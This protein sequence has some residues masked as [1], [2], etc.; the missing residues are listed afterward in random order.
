[1]S[2]NI[3]NRIFTNSIFLLT[4]TL[5]IISFYNLI[6]LSSLS[7]NYE[8]VKNSIESN[9][10]YYEDLLNSNYVLQKDEAKKILNCFIDLKINEIKSIIIRGIII[11]FLFYIFFSFSRWVTKILDLNNPPLD[12]PD[13]KFHAESILKCF[14]I[15][16]IIDIIFIFYEIIDLIYMINY[17]NK[18]LIPYMQTIFDNDNEYLYSDSSDEKDDKKFFSYMKTC[19]ILEIISLIYLFIFFFLLIILIIIVYKRFKYCCGCCSG[20]A[21]QNFFDDR[22]INHGEYIT[23]AYQ[24]NSENNELNTR[25]NENQLNNNNREN[26]LNN[27]ISENVLINNRENN[28]ENN[29]VNNININRRENVIINNINNRE[30]ENQLNLNINNREN[31]IENNREKYKK[32]LQIC[33][34]DT[35]NP[36]K[37]KSHK[38]EE[39]T[40]CLSKYKNNENILILPCMHIFHYDC[41]IDWLKKKQLVH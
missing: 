41:M 9:F 37:Y 22:Y 35:F 23:M 39:C 6:S 38:D 36:E 27:N 14:N 34:E 40:I 29:R 33:N 20:D 28:I 18:Y 1:M 8:D 24:L 17:R 2:R 12:F 25:E 31:S 21:N 13:Y 11:I 26:N 19:K 5:L 3:T 15:K 16:I 4:I 30:N 10:S 7:K 32:I